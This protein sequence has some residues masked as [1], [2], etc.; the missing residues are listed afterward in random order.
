MNIK[1]EPRFQ[2]EISYKVKGYIQTVL[3]IITSFLEVLFQQVQ[4]C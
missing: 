1:S 3:L 4:G 2:D